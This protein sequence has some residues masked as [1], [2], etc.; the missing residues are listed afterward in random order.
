MKT[1]VLVLVSAAMCSVGCAEAPPADVPDPAAGQNAAVQ[2]AG[3][4]APLSPGSSL[5]GTVAEAVDAAN[6]TYL[7]V[8]S[9]GRDVWLATS[10]MTVSAGERVTAT[11]EM[12][13]ENFHSKALNRDFALIYFTP[14]VRREG[15]PPRPAMAVSHAAMG[16]GNAP[17]PPGGQTPAPLP[18]SVT[19]PMTPPPGGVSVADVWAKRASLS[20]KPVTVRGKVVKFN[21]G[22]MGRNWVHIQDGTGAA[23]AGTHDLTITT[24]GVVNVGDVVTATGTLATDKDFGAGYVYAVIL[25]SA[26]I[27]R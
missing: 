18:P 27:A 2:P 24:D 7:R 25:E 26:T 4:A 10:P 13:Q 16:A 20:G 8:T 6:Y 21:G 9:D 3:S 15:E 1:A 17:A 22:I 23:D 12:A 5:T 11:I 19:E 14:D